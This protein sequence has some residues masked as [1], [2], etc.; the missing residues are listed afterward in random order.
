MAL[1]ASARQIMTSVVGDTIR[2]ASIAAAVGLTVTVALVRAVAA[3]VHV[4]PVIDPVIYVAGT[5]V[6]VLAS[7]AAALVPAMRAIRLSPSTALR[8]E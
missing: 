2:T 3:L 5:A 7:T 8:T 4:T 6:V 1:G